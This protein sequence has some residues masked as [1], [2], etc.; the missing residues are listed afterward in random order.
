MADIQAAVR[1]AGLGTA[2]SLAHDRDDCEAQLHIEELEHRPVGTTDP[3][4]R[5]AAT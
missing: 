3:R 1:F 5:P 4:G 2:A